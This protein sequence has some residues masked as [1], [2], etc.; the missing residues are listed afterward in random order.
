M[1]HEIRTVRP[2]S[3]ESKGCESRK[4]E[5]HTMRREEARAANEVGRGYAGSRHRWELDFVLLKSN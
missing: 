1:K 4:V 2:R 5:E 3:S